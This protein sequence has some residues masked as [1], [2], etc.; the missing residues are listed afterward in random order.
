MPKLDS[1]AN[2]V[3]HLLEI[4]ELERIALKAGLL[5]DL[6]ERAGEIT[7][8]TLA[9]EQDARPI[10]VSKAQALR[11]AAE[12]NRL[13]I[14]AARDGVT[15]AQSKQH[16]IRAGAATLK[17]YDKSGQLALLTPKQVGVEKRR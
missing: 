12:R 9:A 14:N 15:A 1:R 3:D 7:R 11:K 5:D 2:P 17:T 8:L 6:G 13:L 16:A 4:M 10:P